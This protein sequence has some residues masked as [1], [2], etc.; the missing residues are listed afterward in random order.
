MIRKRL[1]EI[2]LRTGQIDALKRFYRD[3]IGLE[4]YCQI[5]TA[6]F[7]KVSDDLQGHPQILAV[8]A[9]DWESNG[10]GEPHFSGCNNSKGTLHHIAFSMEREDW[11]K[12]RDRLEHLGCEVR[13]TTYSAMQWRSAYVYDPDG[14]TVEFVCFDDS[15]ANTSEGQ[16]SS[17]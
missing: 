9:E 11:Y 12:E 1:G 15:I 17:R 2:V 13:T 10:P 7:Y 6:Q 3:L 16:S 4:E 8:F 5:G 14:N